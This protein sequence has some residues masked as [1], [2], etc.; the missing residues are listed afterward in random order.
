[1]VR[2][3]RVCRDHHSIP[4]HRA[5]TNTLFVETVYSSHRPSSPS[6]A[7]FESIKMVHMQSRLRLCQWLLLLAGVLVRG[8]A[9]VASV[10]VA[11]HLLSVAPPNQPAT[12][13]ATHD[14]VRWQGRTLRRANGTVVYSYAGVSFH[15]SVQG[16]SRS[17]VHDTHTHTRTHW[18]EQANFGHLPSASTAVTADRLLL[19]VLCAA[20]LLR[21]LCVRARV[22]VSTLCT[23]VHGEDCVSLSRRRS[24][25]PLHACCCS[26]AY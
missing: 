15:F 24:P 25:A 10:Y 2:H 8:A 9:A 26:L 5:A 7:P 20:R 11:P 19:C 14:S 4:L 3:Q 22:F 13:P 16:R 12:V 17:A 6:S 23:H 21:L 18:Q 1:M